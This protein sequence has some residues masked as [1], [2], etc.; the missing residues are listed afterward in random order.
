M[1][2]RWRIGNQSQIHRD[3]DAGNKVEPAE[4]QLW[5]YPKLE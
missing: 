5:L 4:S 1:P 2:K 3:K